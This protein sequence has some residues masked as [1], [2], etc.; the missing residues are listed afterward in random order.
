[1]WL[2]SEPTAEK[3]GPLLILDTH[4]G[5]GLYDLTAPEAV[6]TGEFREGIGRLMAASGDVPDLLADYLARV[7]TRNPQGGLTIYPGSPALA[8]SM[9]RPQDRLAFYE[10]HPTDT[11]TWKRWP[12]APREFGSKRRTAWPVCSPRYRRP[13]DAASC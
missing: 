1:V 4:A 12:A 5:A 7:R 9:K 10:L 8:L 13:S 3:A 11:G 2:S 6:K